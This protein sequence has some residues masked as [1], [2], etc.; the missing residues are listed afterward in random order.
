MR[1]SIRAPFFAGIM[2]A[3]RDAR[4]S[5]PTVPWEACGYTPEQVIGKP[6][7][8]G[9]MVGRPRAD[10][11]GHHRG[12]QP[13]Q[14]AAGAG[15]S[16]PRCPTQLPLTA[17]NARRLHHPSRSATS[18]R[19]VMSHHARS[20]LHTTG[21][22]ARRGRTETARREPEAAGAGPAEADGARTSSWRCWPTSCA[23]RWRRS[24]T[25]STSCEVA[26]SD[27]EAL[28]RPRR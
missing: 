16:A 22:Q 15:S 12:A 23:I 8:Q 28:G 4:R 17:P 14:A 1:S 19:W 3:G 9:A 24:A 18:S 11:I 13:G 7:W 25:A 2:D 21:A 26:G 6:F 27:R 5:E 20:A 10:L